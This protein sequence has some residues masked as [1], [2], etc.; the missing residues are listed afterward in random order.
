MASCSAVELPGVR[1]AENLKKILDRTCT[2]RAAT[3]TKADPLG[4]DVSDNTDCA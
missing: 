2:E 3:V 4:E 1:L